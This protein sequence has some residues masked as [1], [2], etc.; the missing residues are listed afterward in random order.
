[1]WMPGKPLV[2]ILCV[3]K[4]LVDGVKAKEHEKCKVREASRKIHNEKTKEA[5]EIHQNTNPFN[6]NQMKKVLK[7]NKLTN[8]LKINKNK[9]YKR[10]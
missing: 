3:Q 1:M 10:K 2:C 8:Y 7:D 4:N 9:K 6:Y 5:E